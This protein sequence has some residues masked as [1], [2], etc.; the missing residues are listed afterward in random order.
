LL[1]PWW[2][3]H[4]ACPDEMALLLGLLELLWL[5]VSTA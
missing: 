5:L 3:W 1:H 2:W 4:H